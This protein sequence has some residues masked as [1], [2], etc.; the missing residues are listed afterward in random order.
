MAKDAE[1]RLR[2]LRDLGPASTQVGA[3]PE[4]VRR[5]ADVLGRQGLN[6]GASGRSYDEAG[7]GITWFQR[8]IMALQDNILGVDGYTPRHIAR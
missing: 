4:F 2:G 8:F 1:R 7:G 5:V 6:P 3:W